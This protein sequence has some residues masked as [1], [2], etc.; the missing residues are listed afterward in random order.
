VLG[1]GAL[2]G[3]L[4]N[5]SGAVAASKSPDFNLQTEVSQV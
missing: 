1:S 5:L 4:I 3:G 2:V